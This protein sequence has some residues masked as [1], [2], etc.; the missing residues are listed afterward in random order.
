[1]KGIL[2][3]TLL[4]VLLSA[5]ASQAPSSQQASV[6]SPAK[7][8]LAQ[9]EKNVADNVKCSGE[10]ATGSHM[11]KKRCTTEAQREQEKIES[12]AYLRGLT[13]KGDALPVRQ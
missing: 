5:C 12:E 4:T 10:R 2:I 11:R 1:M 13:G 9:T 3:S 8:E 7:T 6:E